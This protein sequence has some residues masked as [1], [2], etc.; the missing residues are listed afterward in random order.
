MLIH[1]FKQELIHLVQQ[2][3]E[4]QHKSMNL[5][6]KL[7]KSHEIQHQLIQELLKIIEIK[8][9]LLEMLMNLQYFPF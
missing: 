1:E 8:H 2:N 9:K 3:D 7:V 4:K 5:K 6:V